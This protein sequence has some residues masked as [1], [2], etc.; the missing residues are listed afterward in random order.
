MRV[1]S[2]HYFRSPTEPQVLLVSI[3]ATFSMALFGVF[4][5]LLASSQA[6][7]FDGVFALID[8]SMTVLSLLVARLL[9]REG[10]RRFQYG[11]WHLEPLVAAFNGS[12]LLILCLYALVNAIRGLIEG[13]GHQVSLD[14]AAAYSVVVCAICFV[15][16]LYQG[17]ANKRLHSELIRIDMKSF[18]MSAAITLALFAG[19]A[20]ATGAE[21]MG[22]GALRPYADSLVLLVLALGLLPLPVTIVLRAMREVFLMAPTDLHIR[23]REVMADV[24]QRHSMVGYKSYVAKTGRMHLVEIHVLVPAGFVSD[25][26]AYDQIRQEISDELGPAIR[27]EQWLSISFTAR[28]DWT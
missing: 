23:V 1:L 22:F 15:L 13:G 25:I 9:A 6:I 5:G 28:A 3:W 17:Q 19:F 26:H 20:L 7:I 8:A 11:Y 10:S 21:H 4:L 24:V 2:Q 12:V 16:L 14:A 27:L 18:V